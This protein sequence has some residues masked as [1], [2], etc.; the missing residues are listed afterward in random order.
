MI[1]HATLSKDTSE[2]ATVKLPMYPDRLP[3]HYIAPAPHFSNLVIWFLP[4][5]HK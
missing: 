3:G 4:S 2:Q 1:H 5:V